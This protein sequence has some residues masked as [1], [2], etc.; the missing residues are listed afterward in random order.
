MRFYKLSRQRV[1][2]VL[3]SP[4]R[5]EEGVAPKTVAMMAPASLK[6]VGKKQTWNQEIWVMVEDRKDER[7]VISAWRYPGVTK[8]RGEVALE[9]MRKQYESYKDSAE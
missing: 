7:V 1:L 2:H 9:Q 3:S 8:P 5:I 6:T 4:K